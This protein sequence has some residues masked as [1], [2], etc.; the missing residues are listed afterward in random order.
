MNSRGL[1]LPRCEGVERSLPM[2][3]ALSNA[4]ESQAITIKVRVRYLLL[5]MPPLVHGQVSV[6][7]MTALICNVSCTHSGAMQCLS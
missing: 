2:T 7:Q 3:V 1:V 5:F 6:K 4:F